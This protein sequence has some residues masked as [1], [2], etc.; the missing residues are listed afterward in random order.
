MYTVLTI[1]DSIL[2]FKG[3]DEE[4]TQIFSEESNST[5]QLAS[6]STGLASNGNIPI[7]YHLSLPSPVTRTM[8]IDTDEYLDLV[9][10]L[11][12]PTDSQYFSLMED[13]NK[14][15]LINLTFSMSGNTSLDDTIENYENYTDPEWITLDDANFQLNCSMPE[16][17]LSTD[18]HFRIKTNEVGSSVYYYKIINMT[19]LN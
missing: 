13:W 6:V 11:E 16:V 17:T 1:I 9:Y 15:L 7:Q 18:Y 4:T 3:V 10:Y 14:T 19:V 12:T 2:G 8:I 5:F